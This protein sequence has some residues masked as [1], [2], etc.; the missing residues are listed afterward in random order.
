M[1]MIRKGQVAMLGC[2]GMSFANQIYSLAGQVR[3]ASGRWHLF[4]MA[5]TK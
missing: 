2:K 3:S 5:L 4:L 1:H